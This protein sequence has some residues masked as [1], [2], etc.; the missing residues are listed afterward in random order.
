MSTLKRPSPILP[1]RHQKARYL[2]RNRGE[3]MHQPRVRQRE[4]KPRAKGLREDNTEG[5]LR[6]SPL[7]Q[8]ANEV[9]KS[10]KDEQ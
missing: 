10:A 7:K 5:H 1:M 6:K 9:L 8:P 3:E 2:K 4:D